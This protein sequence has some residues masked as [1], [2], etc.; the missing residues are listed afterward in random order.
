MRLQAGLPGFSDLA[1]KHAIYPFSDLAGPATR[2]PH[3][4]P[5]KG[6]HREGPHKGPRGPAVRT[7]REREHLWVLGWGK[8]WACEDNPVLWGAAH[9]LASGRH[10]SWAAERLAWLVFETKA[11]VM[12]MGL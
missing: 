10:E 12:E 11:W 9:R 3:K 2:G 7:S 1:K 6:P 5:H 8:E 4:G